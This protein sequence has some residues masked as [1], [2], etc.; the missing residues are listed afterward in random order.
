MEINQIAPQ[1]YTTESRAQVAKKQPEQELTN[2]VDRANMTRQAEAEAKQ[3]A[4]QKAATKAAEERLQ[5]RPLTEMAKEL[6]GLA[7][8]LG[9]S[10]QFTVNEESGDDIIMVFHKKTKELIRQIPSEEVVELRERLSKV[11]GSIIEEKI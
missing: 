7:D 11:F 4:E 8:S 1:T 6:Q 10:V 2:A 9:R 5:A 3:Q